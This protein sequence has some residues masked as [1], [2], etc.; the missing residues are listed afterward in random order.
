MPDTAGTYELRAWL[1]RARELGQLEDVE[2]ADA[3][4]ELG[5]VARLNAQRGG[6]ALLFDKITGYPEGFRV[7]TGAMLNPA[8]LGM[9]LGLDPKLDKRQLSDEV[10]RLIQDAGR[11]ASDFPTRLVDDG[12]VMEN[13]VTGDN[14]DLTIFPAPLWH[15]DDGGPFIGTGGIQI[16]KDPDSDWVNA[17][18]YRSQLHGKSTVGAAVW[19]PHHGAVIRQKYWDK[20]EPAPAVFCFGQHPLLLATGGGFP[21]PRGTSE[22]EFAGAITGERLPVITGPVTGLPIPAHA[23]IAVEGYIYPDKGKLEGP[24]GEFTGYF[25]GDAIDRPYLDV[26]ALYYRNDPIILGCP[27]GKPPHDYS[28]MMAAT[29]SSMI[30]E[31]FG[32]AGIPGVSQVWASEAGASVFWIVT[33]I[34]QQY[35]GHA[36]QAATFAATLELARY[37]IVVDDDIDPSNSDEVI[38]ALSTR[39]DPQADI[40]ILRQGTTSDL[41]PMIGPEDKRRKRM[42]NSRGVINACIPYERLVDGSFPPVAQS[43]P[44]AVAAVRAKWPKLFGRR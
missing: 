31:T 2:G 40:D 27:P 24:L 44:E 1:D 18:T 4:A 36:Q 22:F 17:A 26:K 28:Y 39:T 37:S 32:R 23:E 14:I 43:S 19:M 10:Y 6:P 11:Q 33:S 41:D 21:V 42:L 7:L 13:V 30:K 25:A 15:E 3:R 8:T 9:T 20:G 12:P 35:P 29:R 34:K 5:A 38:W 16:D